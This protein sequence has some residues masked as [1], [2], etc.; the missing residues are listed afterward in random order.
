MTDPQLTF[1][2]P[3]ASLQYVPP[4][5]PRLRKRLMRSAK[6]YNFRRAARGPVKLALAGLLLIVIFYAWVHRNPPEDLHVVPEAQK[7]PH[8]PGGWQPQQQYITPPPQYVPAPLPKTP[9]YKPGAPW[10][11][12]KFPKWRGKVEWL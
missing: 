6:W 9:I 4:P 7:V 2:P 10:P 1:A 8:E 5:S 12:R 11:P 3:P